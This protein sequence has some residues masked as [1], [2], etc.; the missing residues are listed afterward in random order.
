[1]YRCI[2][3]AQSDTAILEI[4]PLIL[5][6]GGARSGKS[7]TALGMAREREGKALLLATAETFGEEGGAHPGTVPGLPAIE[8]PLDLAE[9]VRE[10]GAHYG[11]LLIDCL[12]LWLRNMMAAEAAELEGRLSAL[13][14]AFQQSPAT[15]IA[16]TSEVGCG[17]EPE[18]EAARRFRDEAGRL[19]QR[20]AALAGE[21]YWMVFGCPLRVK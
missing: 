2:G 19:N 7:E 18:N 15:V 16:V 12:T 14:E 21:V 11:V 13:L 6:A 17:I 10:H 20:C 5:I 9:S 4:V 1:M 8:A 3:P